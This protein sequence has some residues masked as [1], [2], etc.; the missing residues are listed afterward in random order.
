MTL[1][2]DLLSTW[3]YELPPD[4][5]ADR[6]PER[7][8]AARL[9]LVDRQHQSVSHHH[10]TDLP[11]LLAAGDL[12]VFNNTQVLPARL[13]G[14][15]TATGGKWEGLFL[16]ES[17]DREWK[18]MCETRG[19]LQPGETITV[20]P[21]HLFHQTTSE[22]PADLLTAALTQAIPSLTLSLASRTAD[23]CWNVSPPAGSVTELLDSFGCL[24]LPPYMNRR[25][26]DADDAT[27]YQTVFA[28]RPGAV[29][30]PTAGLHFTPELTLACAQAGILSTQVTLH[31]GSGTFRP[32]TT[33][34]L[35]DHVMHQ[36]WCELSAD[37]CQQLRATRA[38]GGRIVTVGTTSV[39][40]LESAARF[41]TEDLQPWTGHTQLFIR[42]GFSFQCTDALLTN[43]HLP[44]STLL[45]LVSAFAG[46]ELIQQAYQEAIAQRYRFFSYGDAM[47][48]V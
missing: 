11:G 13:F 21:A 44:G 10:I 17:P 6:P 34:R 24:P 22:S 12:L 31:V 1:D 38:A 26:A 28:A 8:D 33:E 45:V 15:R 30:A 19:R 42:P 4:L 27:R 16:E 43:F 20:I 39:R 7:R 29:A 46:Y 25:F 37:T 40:T 48:I 41:A 32:V 14:F 35:S 23:G 3:Q 36:E 2:L 9:L 5:I 47:L 18:M